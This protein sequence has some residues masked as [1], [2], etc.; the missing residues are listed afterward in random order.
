M[1]G[2]G[3]G[4]HALVLLD[5]LELQGQFQVVGLTDVDPN[6]KGSCV[7]GYQVL[8]GDE[9]LPDLVHKGITKAFLGVGPTPKSTVRLILS[10]LAT[11]LGL[12]FVT[13]IHPHSVVARNAILGQ[14]VAIMAGA[15]VNP[16]VRIGEH[17]T[18]N[19]GAI[20][21]HD[22]VLEDHV[23][24][25]P[26]ACLAGAV[27]VGPGAYVGLGA[28]VI[29]GVQIGQGAIVA[30]GAVVTKDVADGMTVSGVPAQYL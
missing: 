9:V 8:G 25:A 28:V 7:L 6:K 19:S 16:G 17:V 3:A 20:V 22:C 23:H 11:Q 5:I 10:Q 14:G 18:V 13:L 15:I 29:R 1:V 30:A 27:K 12:E 24:V 2:L 21:E 26:G 4:G